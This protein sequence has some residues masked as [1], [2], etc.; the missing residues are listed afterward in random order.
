MPTRD[1]TLGWRRL[2]AGWPWFRGPGR[3]P[4]PCYSEVLPP[5]WLVRRPYGA[6]DATPVDDSDPWGWPVTEYE[7]ALDLRPGLRRV[8]GELLRV[9]ADLARGRPGEELR[10]LLVDNP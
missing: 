9:L 6:F 2:L 8:A 4:L 1:T 10:R 7:E 5:V 3:F